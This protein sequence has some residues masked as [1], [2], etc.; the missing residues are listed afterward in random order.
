MSV[1]LYATASFVKKAFELADI[2]QDKVVVSSQY[3]LFDILEKSNSD[4]VVFHMDAIETPEAFCKMLLAEYPSL[5]VIALRNITD[6]I[7][8]CSLLQKGVKA[9][10]PSVA[11]ELI[12]AQMIKTVSKGNVWI[13][14][15]L[16]QFMIGAIPSNLQNSKDVLKELTGKEKKI[17]LFISDG[18]TNAKIAESMDIS[19][20]TVKKHITSIF[21]KLDVKDRLSLALL[22]K[23]S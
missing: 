1:V 5:N 10:G 16:M 13:Y 18:Y 20:K 2:K 21:E 12:V 7:E 11:N 17:A 19:E 6:F 15:E 23:G 9:Y 14:P 4:I 8:G 22:I 3:E